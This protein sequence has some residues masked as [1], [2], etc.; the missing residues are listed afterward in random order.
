MSALVEICKTIQ[1]E[2]QVG[3]PCILVR[4]GGCN[5][6]CEWCDTK[7]T[8]SKYPPKLTEEDFEEICDFKALNQQI[9]TLMLTG[10][11]PLLHANNEHFED[12]LHLFDIVYIETNGSLLDN[13]KVFDRRP[14]I[15]FNI[16]PKLEKKFYKNRKDYDR[17][18]KNITDIDYDIGSNYCF[19]FKFV[20]YDKVKDKILNFINECDI[21]NK[22]GRYSINI[23][24]KTNDNLENMKENDMKTIEFCLEHNFRFS[25]RAHLY[26][27]KDNY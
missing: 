9:T 14:F 8:W 18:I 16:S 10:G 2:I 5:C 22:F 1:G 19:N 12:I 25:P 13:M 11:E 17:L 27:G 4:L 15:E 3:M 20:Y 24:S 21:I 23:M 7:K 26:I 6:K